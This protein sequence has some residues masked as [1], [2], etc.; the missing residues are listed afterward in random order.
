[1]ALAHQPPR[2]VSAPTRRLPRR[3]ARS[4]RGL[5]K[6]RRAATRGTTRLPTGVARTDPRPSGDQTPCSR[7]AENT[8]SPFT[9]AGK[10][11]SHKSA[12]TA[13]G[14]NSAIGTGH[15]H[16]MAPLAR[17]AIAQPRP[18]LSPT[19][20]A[21]ANSSPKLPFIPTP[22]RVRPS[23]SEKERSPGFPSSRACQRDQAWEQERFRREL[24]ESP[25]IV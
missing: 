8:Q 23:C 24:P 14:K 15:L 5:A 7:R 12:K 22:C 16:P 21:P 3:P 18:G 19:A 10:V 9:V 11:P 1:M 4:T 25:P 6:R 13:C 2:P 20:E 17:H